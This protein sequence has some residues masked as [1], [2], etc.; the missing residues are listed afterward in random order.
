MKGL[1]TIVSGIP[2][3]GM[4]KLGDTLEF[5]PKGQKKK[6]RGIQV[7]GKDAK[8]GR[9]G[10]CVALRLSD[11][12]RSEIKRG[13]VLATPGYF[14]PAR[15]VDAKVYLLPDLSG[16][17]QPRTAVR[18]HVGTSDIPGHLVLPEL[19]ALAPGSE[20]YAQLKFNTPRQSFSQ[21][22]SRREPLPPPD[23]SLQY[24]TALRDRSK[25]N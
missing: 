12:S 22:P 2:L 5:L 1:G 19:K 21:P 3:S 18:F 23:S 10:E 6:V 16:S 9:A 17:I 15:F 20:S 25:L 4:V 11:V 14:T 8:E 13:M 7:Y 24:S